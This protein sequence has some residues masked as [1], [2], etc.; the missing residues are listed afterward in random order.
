V[1]EHLPRRHEALRSNTSKKKK[2]FKPLL[3]IKRLQWVDCFLIGT[4][5][6]SLVFPVTTSLPDPW[7]GITNECEKEWERTGKKVA[8]KVITVYLYK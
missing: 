3:K 2:R 1:V 8:S 7:K 4:L 5:L 6:H